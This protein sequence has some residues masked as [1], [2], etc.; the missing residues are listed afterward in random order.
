MSDVQNGRLGPDQEVWQH[1]GVALGW[2]VVAERLSRT[3]GSVEIE[4]DTITP[5]PQRFTRHGGRAEGSMGPSLAVIERHCDLPVGQG[6]E[7]PGDRP[8]YN[9]IGGFLLRTSP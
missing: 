1:R 2:A 8:A 7:S 9:G 6:L 4:V 3:P 5:S